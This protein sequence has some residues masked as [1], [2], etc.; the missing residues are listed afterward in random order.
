MGVYSYTCCNFEYICSVI[1]ALHLLELFFGFVVWV[2]LVVYAYFDLSLIS[3]LGDAQHWVVLVAVTCW[4]V[5][6]IFII[7]HATG[8]C[9]K[10]GY[11]W[12]LV[13]FI[14]S[15]IAFI[16]YFVAAIVQT[17]SVADQYAPI[18]GYHDY[19]SDW[20]ITYSIACA[21][22]W[23]VAL[24]YI[25]NAFVSYV[26]FRSRTVVC[27]IHN[28]GPRRNDTPIKALSHKRNNED[29]PPRKD[30]YY[31]NPQEPNN[32][33]YYYGK[34]TETPR[35]YDNRDTPRTQD[36]P[37]PTSQDPRP[38]SQGYFNNQ[39]N[40]DPPKPLEKLQRQASRDSLET[41]MFS[42]NP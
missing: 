41:V 33:G 15:L 3:V 36:P 35:N 2:L 18:S 42:D 12:N 4:L 29:E 32:S 40:Y 19:W 13:D 21:F 11:N 9:R 17:W 10:C 30:N 23:L 8:L 28:Q 7:T 38:P 26:Y 24:L 1:G 5:T 14:Y 25:I 16:L 39:P 37:R 34:P 22:S 20:Y 27:S 31:N 6:L